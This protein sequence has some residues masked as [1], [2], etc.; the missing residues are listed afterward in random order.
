MTQLQVL[1]NGQNPLLG[2]NCA[3]YFA[4]KII[5]EIKKEDWLTEVHM[6][7][8]KAHSGVLGNENVNSF[9]KAGAMKAPRI[10]PLL[11]QKSIDKDDAAYSLSF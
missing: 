4:E 8:V 2:D 10:P 3:K 1:L 7:K 9:A 5:K 6:H 11:L